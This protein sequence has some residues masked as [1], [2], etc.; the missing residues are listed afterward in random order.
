VRSRRRQPGDHRRARP[1]AEVEAKDTRPRRLQRPPD[2]DEPDTS[3]RVTLIEFMWVGRTGAQQ[4]ILVS[5]E[6]LQ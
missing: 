6:W 4:V 2:D 1:K 3:E 5:R